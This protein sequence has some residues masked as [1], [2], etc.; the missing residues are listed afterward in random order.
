MAMRILLFVT[1]VALFGLAPAPFPRTNR[2]RN[3]PSGLNG[4][5][6]VVRCEHRGV[7]NESI[8]AN[9][10]IEIKNGEA[11]FVEKKGVRTIYPMDLDAKATPPSFTWKTG[12]RVGYVGSYRLEKDSITLIFEP[13]TEVVDRPKDFRGPTTWKYVLKR[14]GR[15]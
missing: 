8:Q 7:A 6:E 10:L 11:V 5:W 12:N 15:D 14:R 2:P 3:E 9:Y 4:T 1:C 13:G